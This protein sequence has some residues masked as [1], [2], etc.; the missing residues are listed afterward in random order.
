MWT[1]LGA[2][3]GVIG[4]V[5][6]GVQIV[7]AMD[8]P[9]PNLEIALLST[10]GAQ[11]ITGTISDATGNYPDSPAEVGATPVDITLKN[12]GGEPALISRIDTDVVFAETLRDCT[13]SG[14]G[15]ALVSANYAVKLPTDV[16]TGTLRPGLT[17][18]E[19]RFE[20]K[21][22]AVDRMELTIGPDRQPA[23]GSYPVV[24]AVHL[25]LIHDDGQTLDAGTISTVTTS[26]Y[27]EKQI[28]GKL[29]AECAADNLAVLNALFA[30]Q[31]IRS[32]ELEQLRAAY[33]NSA[34]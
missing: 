15:P 28:N 31:S 33:A 30:T 8:T 2:V 12:S 27:A 34:R 21:A 17:S 25:T 26:E 16:A 1:S 10:T 4:V 19:T 7:Q 5:I 20:V 32:T 29:D 13:L 22:G 3:I 11:T 6:S 24:L 14:A 9:P 23:S 18:T